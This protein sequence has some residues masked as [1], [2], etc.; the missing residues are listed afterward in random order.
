MYRGD[1]G[2]P[3]RVEYTM[4]I[5]VLFYFRSFNTGHVHC[6]EYNSDER[7]RHS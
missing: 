4:Q 6:F 2:L 3:K 5:H 1:D 7:F